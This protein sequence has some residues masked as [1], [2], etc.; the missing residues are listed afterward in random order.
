MVGGRPLPMSSPRTSTDGFSRSRPSR[1]VCRWHRV[2]AVLVG[3][4][5]FLLARPAS[6]SAE[7]PFAVDQLLTDRVGALGADPAPVQQALEAVRAETGGALHVVL[8][9]SLE[10]A[11]EDGWA[12]QVAAQSD[13]GSSSVLFAVAV[14]DHTYEWWLGDT[15]PWDVTAVEQLITTAAQPRVVDGDW[16]GAITAL[17]EGL[18]TGEIPESAGG[19]EETA[20]WST[21]TTTAIVGTVVLVLLA[22]HQLSRRSATRREQTRTGEVQSTA[23]E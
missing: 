3:V 15:A 22:G 6:A 17:A 5:A 20:E 14:E 21:A 4:L 11:T 12:E 19:E 8:V 1:G 18:R 10:G 7:P 2:V 9:S 16:N 13:I 23:G